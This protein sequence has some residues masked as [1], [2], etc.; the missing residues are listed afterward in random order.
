MNSGFRIQSSKTGEP[1][2]NTDS[3]L[4]AQMLEQMNASAAFLAARRSVNAP[5]SLGKS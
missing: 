3:D 5:S 4:P 2:G 1:D